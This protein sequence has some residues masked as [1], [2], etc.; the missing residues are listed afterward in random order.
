M[1]TFRQPFRGDYP[2]TQYFGE[3][4]TDPKGHTGVDYGCPSFT[5]IL[6]SADGTVSLVANLDTGY[7]KFVKLKHTDGYET[8]YAHLSRTDVKYGQTVKKGEQ[9]GVSGNSGNSTGPHLHFEVRQDAVL[10]DPLSV[11]QCVFDAD[12]INNNTPAVVKPQFAN[13][14]S[15]ECVVVADVVNVR[16]HCDMSRIIGQKHKGDIISVGYQVTEYMGL[17][18]RDYYDSEFRCWLRIAEHDPDTQ[19]IE[20][21][22]PVDLNIYAVPQ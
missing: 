4:I 8:I 6:A 16:C 22:E 18:F 13:V 21:V 20:N 12:P 5:P 7:G 9:I 2:I 3:K 11:L 17:P 14:Q 15:G 10:I 1:L 19:L